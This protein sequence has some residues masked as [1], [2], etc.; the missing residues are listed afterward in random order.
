M[1]V[2]RK[3]IIKVMNQRLYLLTYDLL[4]LIQMIFAIMIGIVD[5]VTLQGVEK[6]LT[7][8]LI[9]LLIFK[10]FA[11]NLSCNNISTLFL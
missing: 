4:L 5:E 8:L 3:H 2:L 10:I 11:N 7:I 6:I 1:Q 9:I